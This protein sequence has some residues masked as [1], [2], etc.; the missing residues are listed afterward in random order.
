MRIVQ[1]HCYVSI[2]EA[3]STNGIRNSCIMTTE[4]DICKRIKL[5]N[6]YYLEKAKGTDIEVMES[7]HL[8]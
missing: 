4:H 8:Y 5:T 6:C 2:K 7:Q 3:S 1:T